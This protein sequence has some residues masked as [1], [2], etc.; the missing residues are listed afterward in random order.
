MGK[1][2][3]RAVEEQLKLWQDEVLAPTIEKHP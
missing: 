3:G 2:S 1:P